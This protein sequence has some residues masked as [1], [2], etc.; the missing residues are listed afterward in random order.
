MEKNLIILDLVDYYTDDIMGDEDSIC[1]E[2]ADYDESSCVCDAITEIADDAVPLDTN[3]L[4]RMAPE[5]QKYI[6]E[7]IS[8]G[9]VD[10]NKPDLLR[11]FA[12]GHCAYYQR[13]LYDNLANIAQNVLREYVNKQELTEGDQW[14]DLEDKIEELAEDFDHN[15][16]WSDLIDRLYDWIQERQEEAEGE[17]E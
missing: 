16:R 10:T 1:Q 12:A 11:I 15:D 14:D 13:V 4:W 5:I 9:L 7:A 17:A 2:L 8:E 6:E 3:T